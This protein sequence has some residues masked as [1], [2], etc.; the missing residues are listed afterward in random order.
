MGLEQL[1]GRQVEVQGARRSDFEPVVVD[2]DGNGAAANGVVPVAERVRQGFPHRHRRIERFI[3]PL[4]APRNHPAG[5]G[6]VFP[7]KRLRA[8]QQRERMAVHLPVVDELRAPHAAKP[9]HAQH[10]LRKLGRHAVLGAEEHDCRPRQHAVPQQA[11]AAQ[12][13]LDI[14]GA[15]V[16]QTAS[17]HRILDGAPHRGRVQ[18]R[19]AP[20]RRRLVLP[21]LLGV[22]PLQQQNVVGIG[23]HCLVRIADSAVRLL[24]IGVGTVLAPAH[25]DHDHLPALAHRNTFDG[26]ERGWIDFAQTLGDSLDGLRT[27]LLP[28]HVRRILGDADQ[29][30]P[31]T[32]VQHR[33]HRSCRGAALRR[34]FLELQIRRRWPVRRAA[35]ESR[36]RTVCVAGGAGL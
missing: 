15:R 22:Q 2:A 24:A 10:A 27:D 4:H 16:I 1:L 26:W 30:L 5:D 3:D 13:A 9:R 18:I 7:Q 23:G 35:Q 17:A 36:V 33:A 28:D 21:P 31:A 29:H 11:Q 20:A 34:G 32:V 6:I 25:R 12:Q 8:G 19:H 14:A